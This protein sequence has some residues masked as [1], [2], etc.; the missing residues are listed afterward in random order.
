MCARVTQAVRMLEK[1]RLQGPE[2]EKRWKSIMIKLYLNLSLCYLRMRKPKPAVTHSRNA[3][4]LDGR[5]VKATFRLG[6]VC[7]IC[8][9][10]PTR[11]DLETYPEVHLAP[12]FDHFSKFRWEG[13]RL[14][15]QKCSPKLTTAF[16]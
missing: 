13:Q 7:T 1:R 15:A 12:N 3:L 6:Q 10:A 8:S 4:D 14:I 2:E 9:D 11:I 5:N 16:P